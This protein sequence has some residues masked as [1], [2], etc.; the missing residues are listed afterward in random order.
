MKIKRVNFVLQLK[1]FWLKDKMKEG[2][3]YDQMNVKE[4]LIFKNKH[5]LL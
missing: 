1:D 5:L 2:K 4:Q 3:K